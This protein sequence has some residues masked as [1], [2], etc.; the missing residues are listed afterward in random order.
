[1][2]SGRNW[3]ALSTETMRKEK[4]NW[5]PLVHLCANL[6]STVDNSKT[7]SNEENY[8]DLREAFLVYEDCLRKVPMLQ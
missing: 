1:M 3:A 5:K 7:A 6:K 4:G 2:R 8:E